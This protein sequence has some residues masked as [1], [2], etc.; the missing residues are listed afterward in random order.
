M[1]AEKYRLDQPLRLT[2]PTLQNPPCSDHE[3]WTKQRRDEV[4]FDEHNVPLGLTSKLRWNDRADWIHSVEST[5]TP[6]VSADLLDRAQQIIESATRPSTDNRRMP[7]PYLL[8]G[9][10]RCSACGLKMQGN[11]LRDG[12][13]Y[14]THRPPSS[15]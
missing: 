14:S 2:P 6:L 3:T 7:N 15:S 5:H 13:R 12:L 8:K 4:L 10:V 1:P 11:Q 9:M